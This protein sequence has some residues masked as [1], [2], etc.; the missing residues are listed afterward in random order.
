MRAGQGILVAQTSSGLGERFEL[1]RNGRTF[2]FVLPRR[3]VVIR[4]VPSLVWM[5]ICPIAAQR[6][7][8]VPK[9]DVQ[10]TAE[11]LL[12]RARSLSDIRAD[13]AQPFRLDA[14][15]SFT[16]KDF[17]LVSGT[18]SE[19][20]FSNSKWRRE[21][22]VN[23]LHRVEVGSPNRVWRLDNSKNFTDVAARITRLM[24]PFSST[25][26]LQFGSI[27]DGTNSQMTGKCV[28]SAPG[29]LGQ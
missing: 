11:L 28:I 12:T 10:K 4:L 18:Y 25:R 29:L 8:D 24:N 17:N 22:V 27:Q 2:A 9:A 19:I 13:N 15:F 14:T 21:I 26:S 5:L 20:W 1:M 3:R 16:G 7:T 23:D 6:T